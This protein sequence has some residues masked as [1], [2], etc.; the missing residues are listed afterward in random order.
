MSGKIYGVGIIGIGAITDSHALALSELPN[1]K[2]VA[3][4]CRTVQKGR[5]FAEKFSCDY[6]SDYQALCGRDDI[7]V[8]W[9]KLD[10]VETLK[11]QAGLS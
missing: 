7:D 5:A 4:C 6:I 8:P 3:A 11:E 1:A 10:M 9:E 2:L